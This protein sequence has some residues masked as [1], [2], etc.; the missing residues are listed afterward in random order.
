MFRWLTSWSQP[1]PTARILLILALCL[2]SL[3]RYKLFLDED[4]ARWFNERVPNVV[5]A[6]GVYHVQRGQ[7]YAGEG[8]SARQVPLK[9]WSRLKQECSAVRAD[10]QVAKG[11]LVRLT[12]YYSTLRAMGP[13]ALLQCLRLAVEP[14]R[15][16]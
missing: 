14:D 16:P 4:E 2:A 5:L 12:P 13:E 7:L 6:D 11:H 3:Y 10:F 9:A 15:T 8:D 1:V